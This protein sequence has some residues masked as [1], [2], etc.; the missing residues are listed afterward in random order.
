MSKSLWWGLGRRSLPENSLSGGCRAALPHDNRQ[1]NGVAR[2]VAPRAPGFDL[3]LRM[4]SAWG[5]D[6][7]G[8]H[9]GC[10]YTVPWMQ[11]QLLTKMMHESTTLFS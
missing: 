1:K 9:R 4:A 6:I 8:R 2:G 10:T 3:A 7:F 5:T 11:G